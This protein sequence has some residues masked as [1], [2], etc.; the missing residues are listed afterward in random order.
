MKIIITERQLAY[1]TKV[2]VKKHITENSNYDKLVNLQ[3]WHKNE[4]NKLEADLKAHK[5]SDNKEK[6]FKIWE[7]KSK[8][9]YNYYFKK[10]G[11]LESKDSDLYAFRG[12]KN[13]KYIYHYTDEGGASG[14]FEDNYMNQNDE[15]D[16][17]SFTTHPNLW[18]RYFVFYYPQGGEG[19]KTYKNVGIKIKFD[20]IKM[21]N[22]GLKFIRGNDFTG[23]HAGEEEVRLKSN[24]LDNPLKYI[25]E[26]IILKNKIKDEI[27]F[28]ILI[29][30]LNGKNIPYKI[31]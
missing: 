27:Y 1:L 29:D 18:K 2:G 11:E 6:N 3:N 24:G 21:K 13:A 28:E 15:D 31:I 17:I 16:G 25:I 9:L 4:K 7:L 14:I 30:E 10:K 8:R 19:G 23:T 12:D 20:F 22:D 5:Y 26:V